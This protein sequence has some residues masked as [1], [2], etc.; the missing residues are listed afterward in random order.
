MNTRSIKIVFKIY[1]DRVLKIYF[2]QSAIMT[3]LDMPQKNNMCVNDTDQS[4]V[5]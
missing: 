3:P 2:D 5:S 1:F 4:V